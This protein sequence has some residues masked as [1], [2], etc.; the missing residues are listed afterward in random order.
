MDIEKSL[1]L[2]ATNLK[3]YSDQQK[4]QLQSK[5]DEALADIELVK[6]LASKTSEKLLS[7]EEIKSALLEDTSFISSVVGEKGDVGPAGQDG[8]SVTVEEAMASLIADQEFL[9]SVKG[10]QGPA[11]EQGIP[12][13][14]GLDGAPGVAGKDGEAVSAETVIASLTANE[15]FLQAVKGEKGDQG[16]QGLQGEQGVA[17]V[18]GKDVS[19][20]EVVTLLKTSDEFLLAIKGDKGDQGPQGEVGLQGLQ[21]ERGDSVT[22]EEVTKALLENETFT[23]SLVGEQGLQGEVGPQGEKGDNGNSVSADEVKSALILDVEFVK[24]LIGAQGETGPSGSAGPQGEQGPQG[25]VGPEGLSIKAFEI[26]EAGELTIEMSDGQT[27]DLGMIKGAPGADGRDG[28]DFDVDLFYDKFKSDSELIESLKVDPTEIQKTIQEFLA[29]T[30]E[31]VNTQVSMAIEAADSEFQEKM[32]SVDSYMETF[33]SELEFSKTKSIEA[34]LQVAQEVA[35]TTSAIFTEKLSEID[36][37]IDSVQNKSIRLD[38]A[39][40]NVNRSKVQQWTPDTVIKAGSWVEHD[41]R[42]YVANRDSDSIP[43]A[44]TAYS[45]V[46]RGFE[47]RK[48]WNADTTYDRLDVVISSS[49]SAWIANKSEPSGEPGTTP[50]WNL[51]VKRGER[52]AKGDTGPTGL[53]GEKGLDA[54]EILDV[55]YDYESE[56]MTFVKS[57]GSRISF[58]LPV[59]SM[60]QDLVTKQWIERLDQFELPINDFRGLWNSNTT[61]Q[62]GDVVT[63]TNGVS[64]AKQTVSGVAPMEFLSAEGMKQSGD[65]WQLMMAIAPP[66]TGGTGGGG[67]G[68]VGP[69]GPAGPRG[70]IGPKGDT[71]PAGPTGPQGPAGTNGKDGAVGPAGPQGPIGADSTVPGPAGADGA[72]GPMGPKG[73]VGLPGEVG[74]KGDIGNTGPQGEVGPVGPAGADGTVG[75]AGPQGEVGPKG[76][77]GEQGIPGLGITFKGRVATVGDL[78]ATASQGD[79]YIIDSTGDAWVWDDGAAAFENAGPIVGPTGPQGEAGAAGATGPEGPQGPA[80]PTAV[81]ADADNTATLG[82]DGFLY[83]G[84]PTGYL[85]TSGGD[86]TGPINVKGDGA[87]AFMMDNGFNFQAVNQSTAL[88]FGTKSVLGFNEGEVVAPVPF[89]L[90]AAPTADMQVANKKYVDDKVAAGGDYLP[91]SGGTLTGQLVLDSTGIKTG[92]SSEIVDGSTPGSIDFVCN[93]VTQFTVGTNFIKANAPLI[94]AGMPNQ[95]YEPVPKIWLEEFVS[96]AE[97]TYLKLAGGTLTGPLSLAADPA[98]DLEAAT[99]KYVDSKAGAT[100]VSVADGATEPAAADY[101]EGALLVRYTP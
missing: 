83:V 74:P 45:L 30:A 95:D 75:P 80:G 51:L 94:L 47:F 88:R 99:K 56:E 82:T 85:P 1:V 87:V 90:T 92:S 100:I 38:E 19:A 12:G 55:V 40:E 44:S 65:S 101:P 25:D 31:A 26:T 18:D 15:E 21:G 10:P 77:Q 36:Q 37:V 22:V 62:R 20:E 81:S 70:P 98:T 64:I 33:Q 60:I 48:A 54:S 96:G 32:A 69:Q 8:K 97:V 78:P 52:G 7:A 49:G 73:D 46:L 3:D 61:Y 34:G 72:E 68:S 23:K 57:D 4:A 5:I 24:S 14:K 41:G 89:R 27:V 13:E 93:D 71:G 84:K 9:E 59:L 16:T 58:D 63:F 79:M 17:G 50:D 43:G 2:V 28:E 35:D 53:Q 86:M 29:E 11:G 42:Y 76:D 6:A 39:I 66:L 67:E 91:L